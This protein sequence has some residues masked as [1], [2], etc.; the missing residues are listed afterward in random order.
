M[1]KA[2]KKKP[3]EKAARTI[4]QVDQEY[5]EHC[6]RA[7]QLEYRKKIIESELPQL[8]DKINKLDIEGTELKQKAREAAIAAAAKPES[9]A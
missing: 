6:A 2:A 9:K 3:E 4:E 1:G 7:G 5:T 8:Y